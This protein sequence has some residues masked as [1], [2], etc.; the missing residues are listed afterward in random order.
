MNLKDKL[1]EYLFNMETRQMLVSLGRSKDEIMTTMKSLN[2]NETVLGFQEQSSSLYNSV[3]LRLQ[4]YADQNLDET[5]VRTSF[6]FLNSPYVNT[7]LDYLYGSNTTVQHVAAP[8]AAPVATAPIVT[9]PVASP[10]PVSTPVVAAPVAAAPVAEQV[11]SEQEASDHS[12]DEDDEGNQL[13]VFFEECVEQTNEPT[14]IL[15]SSDFYEALTTWWNDK[16]DEEDCPDKKQL[17]EFLNEK[18]GKGK[19]STWTNVVLK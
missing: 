8:V 9:Q 3:M 13:E 5:H 15:K 14:D 10:A 7:L 17:K 16:Y 19:K 11:A 4:L 12:E 6:S 18:L 2:L 1:N